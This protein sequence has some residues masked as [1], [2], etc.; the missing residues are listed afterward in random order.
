MSRSDFYKKM[1]ETTRAS[2]RLV[3]DTLREENDKKIRDS[4]RCAAESGIRETDV[5]LNTTCLGDSEVSDLLRVLRETFA[6][7]GFQ[8]MTEHPQ[9]EFSDSYYGS[10]ERPASIRVGWFIHPGA[11]KS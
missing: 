7:E 8:V 2:R 5:T 1:V 3:F 9:V 11:L 6:G 4:I 10:E